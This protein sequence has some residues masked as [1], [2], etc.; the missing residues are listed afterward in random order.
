MSGAASSSTML[1]LYIFPQKPVNQR[2]TIALL[3]LS[4]DISTSRTML[5][6]VRSRDTRTL[7]F[8]SRSDTPFVVF[9]PDRSRFHENRNWISADRYRER[10][11]HRSRPTSRRALRNSL[12]RRPRFHEATFH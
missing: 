8:A 12:S 7:E 9:E 5:F 2:P 11:A 10:R 4:F 1:T 6:S 3:S